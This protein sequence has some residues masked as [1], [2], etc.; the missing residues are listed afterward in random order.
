MTG[1]LVKDDA[2]LRLIAR[3]HRVQYQRLIAHLLRGF[4]QCADVFGKTAAAITGACIDKVITDALVTAYALAHRLN[5]GAYGF[6]QIGQFVHVTDFGGQHAVG[7][8]LGHLCAA[9]AHDND[10]VVVAVE[11]LIQFAQHFFSACTVGADDD[12]VRPLTVGHG[13]A[14]FQ[15]LGV[16]H[17]VKFDAAAAVTQRLRDRMADLISGSHRHRG[18][19]HHHGISI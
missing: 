2:F 8:V 18:F 1:D 3:F 7:S 19:V 15:K 13:S 4:H 16:G 9:Y 10:F 12:A 11:W 5:V 17:H 6:G 14:F